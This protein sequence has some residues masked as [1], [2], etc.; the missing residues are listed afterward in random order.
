VVGVGSG[1]V[2]CGDVELLVDDGVDCEGAGAVLLGTKVVLSIVRN[3]ASHRVIWHFSL[4]N[5]WHKLAAPLW[6]LS[7]AIPI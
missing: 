3:N 2:G 1:G 5:T 4:G 7:A 6:V